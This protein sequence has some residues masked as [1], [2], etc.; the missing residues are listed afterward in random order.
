MIDFAYLSKGLCGLANVR[1]ASPLAGHSGAAMVAGYFFGE[2]QSELD[3]A[4]YQ[5]IEKELER[6]ISQAN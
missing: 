2:D 4:V 5:G 6:I 3:Q 1:S